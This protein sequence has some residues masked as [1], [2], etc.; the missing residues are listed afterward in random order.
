[1]DIQKEKIL[2]I[3][4]LD[5]CPECGDSVHTVYTKEG[6]GK[7]L[8]DGDRVVC[9]CGQVGEIE[10]DGEAAWVNWSGEQDND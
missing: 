9:A 3:D 8:Y 2:K 7:W 5:C 4:W 1:M 6:S 10:A